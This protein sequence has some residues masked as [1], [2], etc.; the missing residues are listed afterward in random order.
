MFDILYSTLLMQATLPSPSNLGVVMRAN[1]ASNSHVC[2]HLEQRT[3][4]CFLPPTLSEACII[5][6]A[7]SSHMLHV[8]EN[9]IP[10]EV[11]WI[12]HVYHLLLLKGF[13]P[14]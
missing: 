2:F 4:G 13:H 5:I 6:L 12:P 7:V 14:I 3:G 10:F 11:V 9:F 8:Q 1:L